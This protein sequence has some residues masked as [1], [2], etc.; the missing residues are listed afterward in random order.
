M[1][2][3]LDLHSACIYKT[4]V[5]LCLCLCDVIA[6]DIEFEFE[7]W[8]FITQAECKS[9]FVHIELVTDVENVW[10]VNFKILPGFLPSLNIS[11]NMKS[12]RAI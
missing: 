8:C 11:F 6:T 1:C 2:T 7:F 5:P 10:L 4:S 9:K 12:C 3:N